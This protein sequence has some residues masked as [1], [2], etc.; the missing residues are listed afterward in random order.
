MFVSFFFLFSISGPQ[1]SISGSTCEITG[2]GTV[3][4]S[5]YRASGSY[6][7][8]TVIN[9][10]TDITKIGDSCFSYSTALLTINFWFP[11]KLEIIGTY[12]FDTCKN[13]QQ[14]NITNSVTNLGNY[15]LREC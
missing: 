4:Q 12:A 6:Q 11:S 1:Y 7:T 15:M 10:G 9:I 5:S 2:D 13:L 14:L 8:Y 3:D